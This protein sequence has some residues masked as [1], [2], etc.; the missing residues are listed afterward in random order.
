MKAWSIKYWETCGI[1][2][3]DDWSV[4]IGSDRYLSRNAGKIKYRFER[5]G[6]DVFKRRFEAIEAAEQKRL[7]KITSLKKKIAKLEATKFE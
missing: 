7:N 4:P 3:F 2:E 1:E 5:L 6:R